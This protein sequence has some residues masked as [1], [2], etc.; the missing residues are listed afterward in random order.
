M[1]IA[2]KHDIGEQR[3]DWFKISFL[4]KSVHI[5]GLVQDFGI[6]S[7]LEMEILQYLT[8]PLICRCQNE[9][10]TFTVICWKRI[11]ENM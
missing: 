11:R 4:C 1:A 8:K 5:K 7:A 2:T 10:N 9:A 6:S 3:T